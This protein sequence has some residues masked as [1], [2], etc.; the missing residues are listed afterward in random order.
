MLCETE[1]KEEGILETKGEEESCF[2]LFEK[3]FY[4]V[5]LETFTSSSIFPFLN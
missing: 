2:Y 3:F 4:I 1:S 5:F